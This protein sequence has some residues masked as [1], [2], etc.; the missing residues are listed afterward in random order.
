MA[1][2]GAEHNFTCNFA[3]IPWNWRR[4][5]SSVVDLFKLHADR[6][7][8]SIHGCDHTAAEFSAESTDSINGQAKLANSR[9]KKHQLRTGLAHEP[10]M[11]F[12]QGA[13]SATSPMVLK[14]NGFIAAVNTEVSPTDE[15]PKTEIGE[16]WR[17]A[18]LKYGD[19]AIYTRR[20]M[21][22]GLCNFAFD[23]LLGKPCLIVTH[24]A[25]FRNEG[26]E[27]VDFIDRLNSLQS[28]LT[29]RSLGDVI[30]RAY[31]QRLLKDGTHQIRMFGNEIILHNAGVVSRVFNKVLGYAYILTSEGYPCVYY[32]DYDMGPDGY[33]LK[34][35]IDN[36]IWIH[37]KLAAGATE[38]RW[39]DFN[40]FAYGRLGAPRLLVGLNN[41]PGSPRTIRVATTFG[42]NVTIHDYT[43]HSADA[44]TDGGGNVT[45]TIS[46]NKNGLGYV[47]YS[48]NGQGG[49]FA[50]T[51]HA[52]TQDLEGA[53][54]LDILPAISGKSVQAG[55]VWCAGNSVV[56]AQL[57]TVT[58][59]WTETTSIL[60][61]LV[62]PDG[63]VLIS[64]SF[65]LQTAPGAELQATTRADGFHSFR[66]TSSNTPASN[67][68]PA[69]TLSVTYTAPA[70][71]DQQKIVSAEAAAMVGDPSEVGQWS[72]RIP[73]ANVPIHTHVLPTGKV[74]FWRRRNPPGTPDF[75]S[76]NQHVTHA[77][78]W[79]PANPSASA[80][81][82]SNQPTDSKG[83][84]INLF[85][86]G[87]TFL[88]DGRLLVTGGHIFDSLGLNTSTFYDPF[89]DRWSAGPINPKT[90]QE[91]LRSN[92]GPIT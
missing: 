53:A 22:H 59:G 28:P 51:P 50:I 40:V 20:Y 69:Y 29:W 17:M 81:P 91:K 79:D 8:L 9:M 15:P 87:H 38:Q 18:I 54:D 1:A 86:S 82:T 80:K 84:S 52:V 41:D 57:R 12:P 78:I 35:Q 56:R 77:F 31:Q 24:H 7:S 60:L 30:R 92:L 65:T 74:L 61:Q 21:F 19:F 6:L 88:A 44:I 37:E 72:E 89:A 66:L 67:P 64:Q 75:A 10:L 14:H 68:N 32:R 58:T 33:K 26:R 27:L 47:C 11:I 5:R 36:L 71:L 16:T 45:I 42:P 34:P 55:R 49:G 43:G 46:E 13:I 62:D 63:T 3:F 70:T 83:N 90:A 39:K 48:I 4:S 25:D 85:C 2:L 23:V 73:L 76:L